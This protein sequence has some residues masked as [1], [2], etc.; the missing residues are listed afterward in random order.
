MCNNTIFK[1]MK[2]SL[3]ILIAIPLLIISSCNKSDRDL[4][5]STEGAQVVWAITNHYNTLIRDVHR[6][7]VVDS[8]I[9][10]VD[11]ADVIVPEICP[12]SIV[13]YPDTGP[14]PIMINIHYDTIC[15]SK[16]IKTGTVNALFDGNYSSVGTKTLITMTDYMV[17]NITVTAEIKMEVVA[18]NY[19]SM[20]I[21]VVIN[22]GALIDNNIAGNNIT[23]FEAAYQMVLINGKQTVTALDDDFTIAGGGEGI[24]WN[25]IIYNFHI[26]ESLS[27]VGSCTY[28]T[29]GLF[30]ITSPDRID[31]ICN[32]NT[33][34]GRCDKKMLVTIPSVV[35]NEEVSIP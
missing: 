12:D 31:R 8:I 1:R 22:N 18:S 28:E 35:E 25:G 7:A 20:V 2:K 15:D 17:N 16:K 23:L 13:R 29:R 5:N 24:S 33:G 10:N 9:N 21:N 14:F 27:F 4:D 19:D 3:L 32:L 11:S 26:E 30:R 34:N 6:V